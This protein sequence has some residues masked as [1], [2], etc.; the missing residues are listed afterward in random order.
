MHWMW[1]IYDMWRYVITYA[2]F[3]YVSDVILKNGSGTTQNTQLFLLSN[4]SV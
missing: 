4:K 3:V 1:D 2:T